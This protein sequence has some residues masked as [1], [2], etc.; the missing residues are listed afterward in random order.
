MRGMSIK[1]VIWDL[2]GVLVR[3]ED[4][5]PRERLADE[6]GL[7]RKALEAQM[8]EGEHGRRGQLGIVS[9]EAHW[10]RLADELGVEKDVL[11]QRFFAGD[12]LDEA[13]VDYV[14]KL[15]PAYKTGLLSN[16]FSTL[17]KSLS[18]EWGILDAFDEVIIS[19]EVGL[20]KPDEAIY[21]LA[22][23]KLGAKAEEAIFVDDFEANVAGAQ[24]MGIHAVQFTGREQAI[25]AIEGILDRH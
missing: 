9:G 25:E 10:E 18:A 3:T 20:A 2:G 15:R 17:R 11:I 6:L 1:A 5:G 8:F 19:A 14:R 12:Q 16:A 4:W 21:Q 22:L 7:A 23:D 24:D 13:L